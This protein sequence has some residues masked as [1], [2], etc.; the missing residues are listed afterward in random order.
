MRKFIKSKFFIIIVFASVFLGVGLSLL[1]H[2]GYA[3]SLRSGVNNVLAPVQGLFNALGRSLDGYASYFTE[4]SKLKEE[5][6]ELKTRIAE[7]EDALYDAQALQN[8]NEFYKKYLELKSEHLDFIFEDAHVIGRQS[9]NWATLYSL[10]KGTGSGIDKDSPIVSENGALLGYVTEAGE[11]WA[12]VSSILN[13]T[14]SV[15][16][17]DERSGCSGIASGDY[18]LREDG[19]IKMEYTDS[20]ADIQVGDRIVTS[21]LGSIYPKGLSVGVVQSVETDENLRTKYAI[22]KPFADDDI[23]DRV[24]VITGFDKNVGQ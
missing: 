22:I 10:N 7:L 14:T 12:K 19:L 11:N 5:N 6:E 13:S 4:H 15:G 3:S 21:G 1:S 8:D 23:P 9:G 20:E 17:Y 16:V 18:E 24:M 2:L